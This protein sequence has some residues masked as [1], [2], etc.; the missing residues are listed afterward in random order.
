MLDWSTTSEANNKG[1]EIQRS[2]DAR[3]WATLG[4]VEAKQL[5]G[6]SSVL[7]RYSF[8]DATPAAGINYYRLK[9]TDFDGAFEYSKVVTIR[10]GADGQPLFVYPNPLKVNQRMLNLS[11]KSIVDVKVYNA[12]GALVLRPVVNEGKVSMGQLATGIYLVHTT[13][14]D[15]KVSVIKLAIE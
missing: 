8:M 10:F 1:F 12:T 7:Q 3:T 9:Q 15:G 13:A 2:V 6:N 4:T 11:D 14:K 5:D